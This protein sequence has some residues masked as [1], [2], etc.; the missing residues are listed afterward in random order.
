MVIISFYL[1]LL[2]KSNKSENIHVC[3]QTQIKLSKQL[4]YTRQK[5]KLNRV[6]MK[7]DAT[8]SEEDKTLYLLL[9]QWQR[10]IF[11][12]SLDLMGGCNIKDEQ[13]IKG[14]PNGTELFLLKRHQ[15]RATG[16]NTVLSWPSGRIEEEKSLPTP[17]QWK[18]QAKH[19][20]FNC[21]CL[22]GIHTT[23]RPLCSQQVF[24]FF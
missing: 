2:D 14:K 8:R 11:T 5:W 20:G 4:C 3:N 15:K 13:W 17:L 6:Y 21:F 7:E 24:S 10:S 1:Q 16:G 18:K 23:F 22:N 12:M 19:R 9:S